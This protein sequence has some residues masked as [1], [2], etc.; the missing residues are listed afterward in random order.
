L[1]L[2]RANVTSDTAQANDLR[3]TNSTLTLETI[4]MTYPNPPPGAP[5]YGQPPAPQYQPQ[6]PPA[7]PQY[8]QPQQPTYQPLPQ[9]YSSAPAVPA[10][11]A[12]PV[13]APPPQAYS[14]PPAQ[15][16]YGQPPAPQYQPPPQQG[17]GQPQQ[18]YGAPSEVHVP[19]TFDGVRPKTRGEYFRDGMHVVDLRACKVTMRQHDSKVFFV[20]E[21]TVVESFAPPANPGQMPGQPP[22]RPGDEVS[23]ATDMQGF[24]AG[25]IKT[26]IAQ[27]MGGNPT[28]VTSKHVEWAG[29]PDNPFG[30]TR[31]QI[32]AKSR[33]TRNDRTVT[34]LKLRVL[35]PGPKLVAMQQAAEQRQ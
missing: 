34:N 29:G 21:T 10:A 32:D 17:Y 1:T 3:W 12:A 7:Q 6:Q 15:P 11:P 20:M 14:P 25:D 16:Q 27:I 24:G 28:E 26:W 19:S 22:H 18:G 30:G 35:Q 31:L 23:I 33:Q 2:R 13:Y 8:G 5:P 9:Q 4:A